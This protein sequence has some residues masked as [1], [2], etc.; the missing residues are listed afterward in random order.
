MAQTATC[1]RFSLEA[2]EKVRIC[3]PL[4]C[5]HFDRHDASRTEMSRKVDVPHTACPN[6]LVDPILPLENFA[7]H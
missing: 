7:D 1:L 6:L 2:P 5:D 4:W 3:G